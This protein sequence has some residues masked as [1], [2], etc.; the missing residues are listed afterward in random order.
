V[1]AAGIGIVTLPQTNLSL[2]GR[3]HWAPVPRGLTA[4]RALLDAGVTLAAG[5]DNVRDPFNPVGGFDGLETAG[6]LVTAGHLTPLEALHA[7]SSAARAVMGLPEAGP[8]EGAVAD[9]LAVRADSLSEALGSSAPDRV[10]FKSGRI[11]SRT[12]IVR[13]LL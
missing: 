7:V 2:Q 9:L 10:V 8:W 12:R 4:V 11:V 13:E 6:L 1:A 5:G 3:D